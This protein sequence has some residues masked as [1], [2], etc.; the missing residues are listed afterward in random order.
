MLQLNPAPWFM[1]LLLTL[2]ILLLLLKPKLLQMKYLK[3]PKITQP[4]F[5]NLMWTW[6]WF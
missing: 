2:T 1:T 3:N 4:N 6:T 5:K